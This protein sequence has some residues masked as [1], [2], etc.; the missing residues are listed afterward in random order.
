M[1]RTQLPQAASRRLAEPVASIGEYV[2]GGSALA[3]LAGL[4][5][6]AWSFDSPLPA[7]AAAIGALPAQERHALRD[8]ILAELPEL[9][10]VVHPTPGWRRR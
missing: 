5:I 9:Q 7:D 6:G 1:S 4:L 8:A 3:D 2:A 10:R